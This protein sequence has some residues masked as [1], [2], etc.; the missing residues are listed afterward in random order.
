MKFIK[1]IFFVLIIANISPIF[2]METV[3]AS[4]PLTIQQQLAL[5]KQT[6]NILEKK[7]ITLLKD[8][9]IHSKYIHHAL[10]HKETASKLLTTVADNLNGA[11]EYTG[12]E[13]RYDPMPDL[14]NAISNIKTLEEILTKQQIKQIKAAL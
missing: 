4:A 8:E 9:K 7:L 5:W 10:A 12:E 14:N 6:H 1:N 3:P 11:N 2:A 13:Q